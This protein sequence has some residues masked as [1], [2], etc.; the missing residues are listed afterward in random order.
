M[1]AEE[2]GFAIATAETCFFA[3]PSP[4]LA[5]ERNNRS[6]FA[7]NLEHVLAS[8]YSLDS[9]RLLRNDDILRSLCY[10]LDLEGCKHNPMIYD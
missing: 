5:P 6:A 7:D 3:E 8:N 2:E 9:V 10:L 1:K 4:A